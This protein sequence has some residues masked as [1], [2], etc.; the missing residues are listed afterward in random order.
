MTTYNVEPGNLT[1]RD[2]YYE[3]NVKISSLLRTADDVRDIYLKSHD[4][5][6]QFKDLAK[7]EVVSRRPDGYAF[8]DGKR[9]VTLSII[10]QSDENMADMKEALAEVTDYFR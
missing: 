7:V 9:A 4:R 6:Y 5:L 8:A 2:G 1:I 3:Y 10:K